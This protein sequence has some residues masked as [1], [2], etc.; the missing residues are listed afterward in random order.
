MGK[1]T[2]LKKEKDSDYTHEDGHPD[3]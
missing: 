1:K 2:K 3:Y